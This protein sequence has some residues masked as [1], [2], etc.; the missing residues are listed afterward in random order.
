VYRGGVDASPAVVTRVAAGYTKY[1]K[2]LVVFKVLL[3]LVFA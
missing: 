3:V 2:D 1:Y